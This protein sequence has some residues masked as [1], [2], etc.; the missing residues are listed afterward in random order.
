VRRAICLSALAVLASAPA[1]LADTTNSTNWAGYAAHGSGVAF[2]AVR[3][4]WIEPNVSCVRGTRTYSS[5]WV[6]VGGYSQSSRALEQIGTEV[7]CGAGGKVLSS[8]WYEL[9]PAATKAISLGVQPGDAMHASVT[10]TGHRVALELDD[11]TR[12]HSF[13]KTLFA[14]S[15][16][17]SSAEWIV[18]APSEC[19]GQFACRALPLAD[20][21]SVSFDSATAVAID[22]TAGPITGGAWQ[23]TR[24]KL[25]AGSQRYILARGSS[26]A[27]GTAAPSALRGG[28][29][30][31][32]VTFATAPGAPSQASARDSR[33][34]AGYIQH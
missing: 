30:A 3:G 29:S 28:G 26:D 23:R 10:V 18:E 5:Y 13:H 4:A 2:H 16:D 24:I 34:S 31:F 20:F 32:D 6:G 8:A 25:T 19:V 33:L 1:A 9:V 21:G 17:V 14:P 12:H 11:L 15:I 27:T 22:G 7:D